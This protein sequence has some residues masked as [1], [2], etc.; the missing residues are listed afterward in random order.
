MTA[1]N[2]DR[3]IA[4]SRV[5]EPGFIESVDVFVLAN[6]DA[7]YRTSAHY[8]E[9]H[10]TN[11]I[12]RITAS[13]GRFGVGAAISWTEGGVDVALGHAIEHVGSALIGQDPTQRE[14]LHVLMA[15]RCASML[16][17]SLAP[18]DIALW[19]LESKSLGVPLYRLL[20]GFR[21]EIQ[22]YAST[23]FFPTIGEYLDAT[24]EYLD[25]GYRAV[26]FHTW[27]YPDRDLE[28]VDAI[29]ERYGHLDVAWMLDVEG[30]YS[31]R[32]ALRV[33]RRLEEL[34]Y[35]WFEAPLP[36]ADLDGYRW[37]RSK[38]GI[39]ILPAGNEILTPEL[40]R[41]G[42][43]AGCWDHARVDATLAG[44]ITGARRVMELA[45]ASSMNVELQSWGYTL[46][47]AANLHLMLAYPNCRYFEQAMPIEPME[48]AALDHIRVDDTGHVRA[49]NK[50]GLGVD[51]DWDLVETTCLRRITIG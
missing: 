10:I 26:K 35:T 51:L 4:E 6:P 1:S 45:R 32:D 33:G 17:V 28:L 11:T 47:Q 22:A 30:R 38:L 31:R 14:R 39:E 20:G 50:P 34:D 2:F 46:S 36:D 27:C 43:E 9:L 3:G 23:P 15:N 25:A 12:V 7:R 49:P 44:G 21:H 8:D 41:S 40:I 42:I 24:A 18:L 29:A 37:L 13:D 19:D 5:A 16:P 48:F